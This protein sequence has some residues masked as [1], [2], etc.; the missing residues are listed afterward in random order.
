MVVF[1]PQVSSQSQSQPQP[2]PQ[3]QQQH[4]EQPN[5]KSRKKETPKIKR[6]R[7]TTGNDVSKVD[8]KK[9]RDENGAQMQEN[10]M[11]PLILPVSPYHGQEIAQVPARRMRCIWIW[12]K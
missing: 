12:R 10:V 2:Q 9:K 8:L 11:T 6:E 4:Q 7:K 1:K 5:G 3:Q